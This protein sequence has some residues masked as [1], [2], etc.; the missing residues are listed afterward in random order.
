MEGVLLAAVERRN[1]H[2]HDRSDKFLE[3]FLGAGTLQSLDALDGLISVLLRF[4][5]T[6]FNSATL[7]DGFQK[8]MDCL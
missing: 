2:R 4:F 5:L 8:E 3:S 6:F 1:K 7:P